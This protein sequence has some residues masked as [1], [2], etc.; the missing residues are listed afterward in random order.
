MNGKRIMI[1]GLWTFA[2]CVLES[3][4]GKILYGNQMGGMA[5]VFHFGQ[6][7]LLGLS[8]ILLVVG[9]ATHFATGGR[10]AA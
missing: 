7:A 4:L 9:A 10:R 1:A 8:V 2:A 6:L 5:D 3:I